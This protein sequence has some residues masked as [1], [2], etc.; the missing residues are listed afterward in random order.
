MC[1]RKK[2]MQK[3]KLNKI[4]KYHKVNFVLPLLSL[5]THLQRPWVKSA[6]VGCEGIYSILSTETK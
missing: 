4:I 5:L 1:K 2:K 3:Y 6:D